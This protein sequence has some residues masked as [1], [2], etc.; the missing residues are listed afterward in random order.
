MFIPSKD[1]CNYYCFQEVKKDR[2]S[3]DWPVWA[4]EILFQE[5]NWNQVAIIKFLSLILGHKIMF[6]KD[7][8]EALVRLQIVR[9]CGIIP[10]NTRFKACFCHDWMGGL[11]SRETCVTVIWRG[12]FSGR[13]G[14]S[15]SV[16][17]S[18]YFAREQKT[19]ALRVILN[20]REEWYVRHCKKKNLLYDAS[21]SL[22]NDEK[23]L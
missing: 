9:F 17:V 15:A 23:H 20:T 18:K 14:R 22:V 1:K 10:Q 7:I 12:L 5:R 21:A 13:V 11:V 2:K 3:Q 8:L 6:C 16:S 19:S 4:D